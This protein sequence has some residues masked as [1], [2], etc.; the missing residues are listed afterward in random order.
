MTH[1]VRV[2]TPAD[3]E[4][5]FDIRTSVVQNH[6]S[7]EQMAELGIDAT[8]LAQALSGEPCA[9]VAELDGEP[10]AFSMV[11]HDDASVFAVFVKPD[12][13]GRG[14]GSAVLQ[15]AEAALFQRHA[16]IWLVTDGRAGIRANG[17]YQ[18]HGW[19]VV[20]QLDEGDVRYEKQRP[21]C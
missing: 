3:I 13:E 6:L 4:S 5:L 20:R 15:P 8:T 14:L 19:R 11:D 17:F 1:V 7:R 21:A 10:V 9:W 2:A 16:L 12:F 18:R